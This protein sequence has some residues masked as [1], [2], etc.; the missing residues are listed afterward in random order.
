[1]SAIPL[2]VCDDSGMARKQLIRALPPEWPVSITQ[3]ANGREGLKAIMDG[4]GQVVLLDLTMPE[5]DGYQVLQMLKAQ[6]ISAKVIVVSGD[7]QEEAVRRVKELGALAFLQKPASPELVRATLEDLGLLA[8]APPQASEQAPLVPE[9]ERPDFKVGF[10]DAFREINNVAMGQAAALLAKALGVFVQLPIPNVNIFEV[11]ELSMA[12]ADVDQGQRLSAVCQ[13]YIGDGIAG[14][15]LLIFHDS[16][17]N[18]IAGLLGIEKLNSE[19]QEQELLMDLG[20]IL[21]GA[22]LSGIAK[23]LDVRFS[24]GHPQM[25]GQHCAISDLMHVNKQR[26]K[27]TL[28]VEISYGLEGMRVHFD[29]LLLFTE[30][31]VKRLTDKITHLMD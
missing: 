25:L 23:Q 20:S 27:K 1:M 24:Q 14:E 7:V 3:A 17:I 12:L 22:C 10:R 2:V 6:A 29:L 31:S 15:A 19:L 5:M 11:G 28:G 30:D 18:D 21:I 26:W 16:E 13:G 8:S 9:I 4:L